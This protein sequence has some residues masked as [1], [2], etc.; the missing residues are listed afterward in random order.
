[1]A[2]QRPTSILD[3]IGNTPLLDLSLEHGGEPWRLFAK[4]EFLNPSG[5]VKDRIAKYIIERAEE[6]GELRP[7]SLIAEATSGNTGI[8][9]AMVAA[10]KGYPLVIAMPEH[11]SLERQKIMASLGAT[12]CLTPKEE[13]FAGSREKTREMAARNAKVFLPRQFENPDNTL[14]HYH[15]TG[16]EILAQMKGSSVA[17]FVDGVG[18]GGTLMGVGQALREVWP[19]C[20]VVAVEP[21]EAAVLSGEQEMHD[22]KIAGIGDGFIPELLDLTKVD[23]VVRVRS[24]DAVAMAR[25]LS[26][27]FGLMVGVS[28]GANLLASIEMLRSLG[29]D[30]NV[31]TVLPDRAERYFSTD[32]FARESSG[33]SIRTCRR[34]CEDPFCHFLYGT[35]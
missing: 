29:K 14:C 13:S 7:G 20:Q 26:R 23:R 8:G 18:T 2:A 9:L 35:V 5:S 21:D 25:R 4:A 24:D 34:E 10:V 19:K 12:L 31:V 15:T 22:H 3:L 16:Q 30:Q 11:M 28:S 1:M 27:E 33:H 6:R 17:A 32:L